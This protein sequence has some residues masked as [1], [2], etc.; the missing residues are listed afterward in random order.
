MHTRVNAADA[1]SAKDARQLPSRA[2]H[3]L[4]ISAVFGVITLKECE[5]V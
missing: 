3:T 2:E 5:S 1:V 4:S